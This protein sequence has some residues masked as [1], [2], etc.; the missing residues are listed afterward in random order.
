MYNGEKLHTRALVIEVPKNV[1]DRVNR[2][3]MGFTIQ[4]CK[5]LT[6]VPF[7]HVTNVTHQNVM[8]EIFFKQ[9]M[10]LHRTM[11]KTLFGIA[12]ATEQCLTKT[13]TYNSFQEWVCSVT[14]EERNFLEACEVG[15]AN[16]VN[17]IYDQNEEEVVQQLF[18]Q[19]VK[20]FAGEMFTNDAMD[21]IFTDEKTRI[22]SSFQYEQEDV[23]YA[24]F[25][26][27]KFTSN[28]QDSNS[29]NTTGG[30]SYAEASRGPPLKKSNQLHYSVFSKP[31]AVQYNSFQPESTDTNP[32]GTNQNMSTPSVAQVNNTNWE[33]K[34]EERL[35]EKIGVIRLEFEA[36]IKE[37][38]ERTNERLQQ[39]EESIIQKF[40]DFQNQTSEKMMQSFDNRMN[41]ME[42]KFE[43]F[44]SKFTEIMQST[45]AGSTNGS[46]SVAGKN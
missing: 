18:G 35:T 23:D 28:P 14:Y 41:N 12:N 19:D 16:S 21:T 11:K 10:Y 36:Q 37:L 9:N 32:S 39:N 44:F 17:L 13:G 1:R 30:K 15:Q 29:T 45:G 7:S 46:A 27:R 38:E 22:E 43:G 26:K 42:S 34:M 8:V 2:R 6:Y 40:K 24:T 20:K 31:A 4:T 5:E 25:L 33:E 3:M